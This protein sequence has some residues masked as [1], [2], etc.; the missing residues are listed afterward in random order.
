MRVSLTEEQRA[1]VAA[2]EDAIECGEHFTLQGLAGTGKTT[3]AAHVAALYPDALLCAPTAKAATVLTAK[4]GV[5][6]TT[7][8]AAFYHFVREI[9][10]E[11]KPPRLVFRPAHERGSLRGRVLVL[12]E[13][14]M[15]SKLV[16]ADI[17]A[18]G[19][20]VI[21]I[22][23]PGQL[24]PV[25]GQPFFTAASF[26]LTQIHRQALDNPII[27]QAH[28]VRSGGAYA[29]D[30]EAVR[31]VNRLTAE[32]LRAAEVVITGRRDTRMRMNRE[33]RRVR[34]LIDHPLPRAGD[35][36]ICLRN[37]KKYGLCNGAIYYATR[38]VEEG[39]KK[40]AIITD[41][42]DLEVHAAFLT[43]GHE[44]D[45]LELPPG[46][47]MSAFAFGY[48]ITVYQ[49]QG[50]EFDAVLL[51]DERDDDRARHLYTGITRAKERITIARKGEPS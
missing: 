40:I 33:M 51:I 42:G 30:G 10:Q 26:R 6:A 41:V 43:H 37:T 25:E 12:D 4:T 34:G 2:I 3:V 15:I 23:D 32:E 18:T 48:A 14:S 11:G 44:Y 24:P 20:T 49:A 7:V 9:E 36:L 31:V 45:G 17:L 22:G 38:D 39:D 13:V 8:H 5:P 1:A 35:R 46:G 19:I 28:A 47:W 27:R 29:P 16:A 21:A 50:S